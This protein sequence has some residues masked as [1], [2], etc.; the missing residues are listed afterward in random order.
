[1]TLEERIAELEAR[2]AIKE[3]RA[4]YGWCAAHGDFVG[5]ASLFTADGV[6]EVTIGGE[7]RRLVGRALID[8]FL[9]PTMKPVYVIPMIHNHIIRI[10][11]D[12]AYGT[13]AMESRVAPNS[14]VGFAGYYHDRC[15]RTAQG[16]LF[17]E[18]SWFAYHP[19][20]EDSGLD[21]Y[22]APVTPARTA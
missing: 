10:E 20:F 9:T 2:E 7:R 3:L 19:A 21:C 13:C 17:T 12:V 16:W 22:G 4:R 5:V 1:M 8:G 15:R 14:E 18:R 6:F 11:G